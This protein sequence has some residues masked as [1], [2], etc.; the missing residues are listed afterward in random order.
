MKSVHCL[1]ILLF[2]LGQA[3]ASLSTTARKFIGGI[4]AVAGCVVLASAQIE[5]EW[6]YVTDAYYV[7][8]GEVIEV[9]HYEL[10]EV[11]RG[12]RIAKELGGALILSI[13]AMIWDEADR[14]EKSRRRWKFN[15]CRLKFDFKTKTLRYEL[16]KFKF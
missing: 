8:D 6:V 15:E 13:G 1:L 7:V 12:E 4:I 9:G 14:E 2:A 10:Q 11:N 16:F 5:E 3:K